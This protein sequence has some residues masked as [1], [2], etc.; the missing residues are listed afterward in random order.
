[1]AGGAIQTTRGQF[2]NIKS[3]KV[4]SP[5]SYTKF[6]PPEVQLPKTKRL[7]TLTLFNG[8]PITITTNARQAPPTIPNTALQALPAS[9][10]LTNT[11]SP[12]QDDNNDKAPIANINLST[13]KRYKPVHLKTK[14]V[15]TELPNRFRIIRDI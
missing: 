12:L 7:D 9:L 11:S 10:S 8:G 2:C 14:P 5:H 3:N 4:S 15:I 6:D 13:K 1:M